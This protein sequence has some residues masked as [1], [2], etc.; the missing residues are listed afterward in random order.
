MKSQCIV[1]LLLGWKISK[2]SL[3]NNL[4][5]KKVNLAWNGLYAEGCKALNR[6]LVVNRTLTELD[7]SCNRIDRR[8]MDELLKGLCKNESIL[9]FRVR[10][11][12]VCVCVSV[13]LCLCESVC[14]YVCVCLCLCVVE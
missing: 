6:A 7:V 11:L 2:F 10:L 4:G 13:C 12:W 14:V 9:I 1:M 5:L 3:Q 8:C